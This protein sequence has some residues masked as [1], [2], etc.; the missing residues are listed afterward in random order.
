MASGK[1]PQDIEWHINYDK[2]KSETDAVYID[3]L[4][5][6]FSRNLHRKLNSILD[7]PCGNGRLHG[8]LRSYAYS[9]YGV[10][11]SRELISQ[12]R[13]AYQSASSDYSVGDIRDFSLG[14]KFDVYL[15]WFT[16]FGYFD[17]R[18][19]IRVLRTA[20]THLNKGGIII[21]DV[22]DG[23][24]TKAYFKANPKP[25]FMRERSGEYVSIERPYLKYEGSVAYQVRNESIYRKRSRDLLFVKMQRLHRLRLYSKADLE[26]QLAKTGFRVLRTFSGYSF[27]DFAEGDKRIVMVASKE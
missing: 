24:T 23:E 26:G 8:Y 17:D 5:K 21:I 11:I 3:A 14:R 2:Q 13:R 16:S 27:K 18:D 10:D 25:V 4:I 19:N 12:A 7:A 6:L 15:S 9:V 1:I 20:N 22:S